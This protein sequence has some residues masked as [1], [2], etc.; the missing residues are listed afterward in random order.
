MGR[1]IIYF[2]FVLI[3]IIIHFIIAVHNEN[4]WLL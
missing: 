4:D 2:L 3:I 1:D